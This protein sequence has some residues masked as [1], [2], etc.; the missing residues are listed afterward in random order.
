MEERKLKIGVAGFGAVGSALVRWLRTR[1]PHIVEVH[2]PAKGLVSS[3]D[4][5]RVVFI[6]VSADTIDDRSV[7]LNNIKDVIFRFREKCDTFILRST[8]LPGT[9]DHL[10]DQYKCRV[11]FMPEFLTERRADADI[12]THRISCGVP[13][14][15]SGYKEK[16]LRALV[17]DTMFRKEIY[18]CLNQEAE[19][20]KYTSNCFGALKVHYFNVIKRVCDKQGLNYDRVLATA[21]IPGFIE[22]THTQVPGPD[23]KPGFGGACLPKDLKAFIGFLNKQGILSGLFDKVEREN[24]IVRSGLIAIAG[25]KKS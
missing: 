22:R 25:N 1:T 15:F 5:C 23:G 19:L 20:A 21:T 2:D 18:F 9:S 17:T 7:D 24:K 10:S 13:V 6:C 8:V 12:E 11:L 3:F 4:G 16:D 14:T